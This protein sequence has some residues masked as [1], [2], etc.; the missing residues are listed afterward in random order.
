MQPLS[1]RDAR[2][3]RAEEHAEGVADPGPHLQGRIGARGLEAGHTGRYALLKTYPICRWSGELGPKVKEGDR[4]APEGFY[5]ITPGADESE[6]AITISSFNIGYPERLRPRLRPHRR[7]PDGARRLLVARLLRDDR[8]ADRRDLCARRAKPSSA[9]SS[10]FQVQAYPFR[11][12]PANMAQASQQPE[13]ARSGGCSRKATT[14]SRSRTT[15]RRSTSARSATCS[16]H[17]QKLAG[18]GISRHAAGRSAPQ[19]QAARVLSGRVPGY[20]IA[21]RGAR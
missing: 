5:T 18:D 6:L 20:E 12:T 4:Q 13:H 2:R 16:M 21:E 3:A 11:M 19:R 14:I 7:A 1:D 10:A 8:R 15:S 17:A 9:A